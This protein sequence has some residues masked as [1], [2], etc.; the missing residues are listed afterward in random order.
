MQQ[1]STEKNHSRDG[2]HILQKMPET[3]ESPRI[4]PAMGDHPGQ[5]T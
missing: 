4:R 5:K 1:D 3:L 2:M